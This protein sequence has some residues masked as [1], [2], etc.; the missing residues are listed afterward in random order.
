MRGQLIV[1]V[2]RNAAA[3]CLMVVASVAAAAQGDKLIGKWEG[4]VQS[5]QGERPTSATFTKEGDAII[6][7]MG[8]IRPGA[9]MTLK[10]VKIDGNKVTAKADVE[11]P[12]GNLT[13][14]YTFTL[15]GDSLDGQ[16]AIDFGGQSFNFDISL[17]RAGE[18]AAPAA[19]AAPAAQQPAAG[20]G[21]G[22]GRG[23]GGGQGGG[24]QRTDVAQPQQKQSIDYFVGQW[25][26][27][28]VGR[29]SALWQAPRDCTV[30][31][32]KR[33]D[34]RSVE[35]TTQCKFEGGTSSD[36]T[37]IVFDDASR[38]LNV[39][40][41]LSSG[42]TLNMRG[43][44]TSPISIRYTID[45]VTIKGQTLQLR[46]TISVVSAHSFTIAEDLSEDGGPFVRLGSAVVSKAGVQ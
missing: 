13:I 9:E 22:Q 33:A 23:Q 8:G 21:A 24:R 43:D 37:V 39:T 6:G 16:G 44:W 5:P 1:C 35:G 2:M 12:Q 42:A 17:K 45:P 3:V 15:E 32:A 26:Y 30:T 29:E 14:N 20:Q 38:M 41:K 19:P 31:F 7:K 11:S 18:G 27:R 36:A 46:R 10:D 40:E 4:K 25:S 34:G 28:Y